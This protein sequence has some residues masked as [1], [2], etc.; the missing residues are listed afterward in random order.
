MR[1]REKTEQIKLVIVKATDELLYHKSYNLMSFSDI[2]E[3][4][5]I[6]RGNLNYH[7]KTKDDI[8]LA[9][10]AYRVQQMNKMLSDWDA[11]I[12]SPLERLLRFAQIPLNE[13][14]NVVQH[15]C[16]IGTLNQEL[17]KVQPELKAISKQQFDVFKQW[18]IKQ[19]SDFVPGQDA[20]KLA[21]HML[22]RSQGLSAVAFIEEDKKII[23]TEVKAI[24]QWLKSL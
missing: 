14:N 9:V 20:Q 1:A 5:D 10:V 11:S 2:A 12:N 6:P 8:L 16:P 4:S 19:F 13:K 3:A 15:G 17:G 22:V 7:F 23:E 18:L 24:E 21:V